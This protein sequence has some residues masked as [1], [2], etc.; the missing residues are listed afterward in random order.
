MRGLGARFLVALFDD[1]TKV[2]PGLGPITTAQASL[3]HKSMSTSAIYLSFTF[4]GDE[5]IKIGEIAMDDGK[6]IVR[7]YAEAATTG[8]VEVQAAI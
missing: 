3:G 6:R 8:A 5:P 1:K 2:C 7:L 4:D